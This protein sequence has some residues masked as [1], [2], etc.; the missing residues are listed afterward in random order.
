[1]PSRL[2][3]GFELIA[4][5]EREQSF[6]VLL[7][8]DKTIDI[9]DA[10]RPLCIGTSSVRRIALLH[11]YFPHVK[12]V[13][14]RG[15]LQT[16]IGKL[17]RGDCDALMLAY[18][19]VYRM[20]YGDMIIHRFAE[21]EIVPPVGQGC[22]AVEA[23]T[24]LPAAKK[25]LVRDCINHVPAESCLLAERAYLQRLEGGCSIP[26]FALARLGNDGV[27][28]VKAG[29]VGLD[30]GELIEK[31]LSGSVQE[32][33]SLGDRLATEVLADGGDVLLEQIRL[34]QEG[35]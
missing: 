28:T 30:G 9:A 8:S 12:C 4:F 33:Q 10:K 32:A 26:A 22:I 6:D 35:D 17:E 15:N 23:A 27:L 34:E 18:A 29:L 5:T 3:K 19:G 13:N 25:K 16:R 24:T 1:M 7:S 31:S 2:P 14:M 11:H 20:G 21:D